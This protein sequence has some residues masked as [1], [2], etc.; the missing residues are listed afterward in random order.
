MY[1]GK[2]NH[3]AMPDVNSMLS[4]LVRLMSC[5][6]RDPSATQVMTLL[7]LMSCLVIWREELM[8]LRHRETAPHSCGTAGCKKIH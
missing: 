4:S 7:H 2:Y 8:R 5:Y 6:L 1:Y 3:E